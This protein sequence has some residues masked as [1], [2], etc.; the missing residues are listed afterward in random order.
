M[1]LLAGACSGPVAEA[2]TSTTQARNI[3]LS[4]TYRIT[5]VAGSTPTTV[6]HSR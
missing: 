5:R 2:R 1:E 4:A 3:A 6:R